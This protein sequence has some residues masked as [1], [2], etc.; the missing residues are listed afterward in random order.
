MGTQGC[1]HLDGSLWGNPT[2]LPS[3]HSLSLALSLRSPSSRKP[4]GAPQTHVSWL[5]SRQAAHHPGLPKEGNL[6]THQPGFYSGTLSS[7][8]ALPLTHHHLLID[9]DNLVSGQDLQ[10]G[11]GGDLVLE[12]GVQRGAPSRG[13][14]GR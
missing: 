2:A 5:N 9:L 11:F 7:H 4:P 10:L 1:T 8:H 13:L 14:A 12:G 3:D 6:S